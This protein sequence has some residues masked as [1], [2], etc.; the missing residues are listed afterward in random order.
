[1][2]N[3]ELKNNYENLLVKIEQ[4]KQTNLDVSKLMKQQ[5]EMYLVQ[6]AQNTLQPQ[7]CQPTDGILFIL[8]AI[9]S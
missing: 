6:I 7:D 3:T 5:L 2:N 9:I 4:M 1:M 8:L